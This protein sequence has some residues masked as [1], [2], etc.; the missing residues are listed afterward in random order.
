MVKQYPGTLHAHTDFSNLRL[1]DSI[2]KVP[3]LINKAIELG[4]TCVA[5]TDHET[6]SSFVQVEGY[7]EKVKDKKE[8]LSKNFI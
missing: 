5:I 6:I 4:H 7:A 3:T 1:R 8:F 2:N